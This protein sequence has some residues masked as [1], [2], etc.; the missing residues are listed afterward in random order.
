MQPATK[1]YPFEGSWVDRD[2]GHY[3]IRYIAERAGSFE[4]HVWCPP[5]PRPPTHLPTQMAGSPGSVPDALTPPPRRVACPYHGS[6]PLTS[7]GA[8]QVRPLW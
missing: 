7:T 2:A 8:V 3:E 5:P 6:D 4:L 1:C